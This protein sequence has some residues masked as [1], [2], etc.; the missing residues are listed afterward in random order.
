ML[1]K[2]WKKI[3]MLILIIACTFNIMSK[4]ANRISVNEEMINSVK[5]I[6][7]QEKNKTK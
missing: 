3:A 4:L 2:M 1:E 7:Q 6:M 5:Y